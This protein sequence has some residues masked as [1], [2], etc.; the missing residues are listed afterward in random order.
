MRQVPSLESGSLHAYWKPRLTG[1]L[2]RL[3]RDHVVYSFL[4]QRL[5]AVT[6]YL[7]RKTEVIATLKTLGADGRTI[8]LT[9][10]MQI[11]VLTVLG[12]A[13]GLPETQLQGCRGSWKTV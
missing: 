3:C 5:A 8:F 6:T 4:P 11:G 12:L 10:F 7:E 9:Y 2:N 1:V 13:V